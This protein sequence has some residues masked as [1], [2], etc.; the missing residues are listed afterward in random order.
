MILRGEVWFMAKKVLLM[1]LMLQVAFFMGVSASAEK[2]NPVKEGCR[3]V[4][5]TLFDLKRTSENDRQTRK[6]KKL[7]MEQLILE[8]DAV[9]QSFEGEGGNFT[10][11]TK[12]FLYKKY[13]EGRR[14]FLEKS[15]NHF[16]RNIEGGEHFQDELIELIGKMCYPK[17]NCRENEYEDVYLLEL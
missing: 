12:K 4:C 11:N 14:F 15:I 13:F 3:Q 5:K 1:V 17:Y 16:K 10:N 6:R 7:E 9:L 2:I 8:R